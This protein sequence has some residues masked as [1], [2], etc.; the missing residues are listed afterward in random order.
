MRVT[1]TV[2]TSR[3][4]AL[5][6][7]VAAAA[8]VLAGCSSEAGSD[9]ANG[10][11]VDNAAAELDITDNEGTKTVQAPPNSVVALDNRTFETLEAWGVELSAA[12]RSLMPDTNSMVE[13][14]S[15]PDVGN[16]RE[17]NLETIVAAEPDVVI[18]GQRFTQF[19]EEIAGLVPDAEI[20]DLEPR[21]GEDFDAELKRQTTTLGEI[22]QKQDEAQALVEE[23]EA[24]IERVE[25]A[26]DSDTS[27]MAVNTSG[28]NINYLAPTVG[29]TLGPVFDIFDFTPALEVDD[30]SDDHQGDDISVE[31]IADSN[32]DLILVMDR[33]AAVGADEEGYT[34]A[35][36]LIAESPALQ[37]VGAVEDGNILI[38]P[39]DTYTN[40]GIQTYT[41]FFNSLADALESAAG[42]SSAAEGA[43]DDADS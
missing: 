6:A 33:D 26:Y 31:A 16:H 32:P 28:G 43:N 42:A 35:N 29:R 14:E 22:F 19:N 2:T 7:G 10:G 3:P 30:A 17:P 15:I 8:L 24:S 20:I 9:T 21:E 38:M 18:S 1:S 39:E 4:R 25:N 12:A 40:E 23:F 27:V 11:N 36:A 34:P 37:N 13:N 41:E 5:I